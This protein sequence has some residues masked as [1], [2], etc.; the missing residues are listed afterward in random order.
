MIALKVFFVSLLGGAGGGYVA[1]RVAVYLTVRFW[2]GD[3]VEVMAMIFGVISALVVGCASAVTAGVL[4][5]R[6]A[7]A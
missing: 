2:R 3:Q 6:A 5:G 7:R 1:F 4:A